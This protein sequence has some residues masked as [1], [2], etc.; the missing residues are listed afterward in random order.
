MCR[1]ATRQDASQGC[2]ETQSEGVFAETPE[3]APLPSGA[4]GKRG[5]GVGERG[6][7]AVSRTSEGREGKEEISGIHQKKKWESL[8]SGH[9]R[10]QYKIN[11][12]LLL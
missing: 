2:T 6:Q 9:Q 11:R 10:A 4:C 12:Q 3:G 5:A 7:A 8:K 1:E